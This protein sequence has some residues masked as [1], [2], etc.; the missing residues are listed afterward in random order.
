VSIKLEPD[1]PTLPAMGLAPSASAG[2][3]QHRPQQIADLF[4]AF[5]LYEGKLN[6]SH[7]I[8]VVVELVRK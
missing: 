3:R 7:G 2:L 5:A 1:E 6:R 4:G 8:E